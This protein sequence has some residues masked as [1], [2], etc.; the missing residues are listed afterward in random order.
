[1]FRPGDMDV[2]G[3]DTAH[4]YVVPADGPDLVML[5]VTQVGLRL[6]NQTYLPR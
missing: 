5:S 2:M 6:G 3:P 1:V 4:D